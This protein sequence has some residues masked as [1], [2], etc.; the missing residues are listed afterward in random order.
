MASPDPL[1][2]ALL[3]AADDLAPSGVISPGPS[4]AGSPESGG[5]SVIGDEW[6]MVSA[7]GTVKSFKLFRVAEIDCSDPSVCFSVI[8]TNSGFCV[9]RDCSVKSYYA[10][11]ATKLPLGGKA[12]F[13]SSFF[14][15]RL[16]RPTPNLA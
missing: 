12:V 15:T 4:L 16:G 13:T 7:E 3:S 6:S 5:G 14:A 9:R 10:P 8:G 11:S 1:L 2:A